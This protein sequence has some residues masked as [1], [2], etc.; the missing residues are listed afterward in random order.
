MPDIKVV[1]TTAGIDPQFSLMQHQETTTGLLDLSMDENYNNFYINSHQ[2]TLF[3]KIKSP[4][5]KGLGP[6]V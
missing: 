5:I 3:K 6:V 2:Q 4:K 1:L